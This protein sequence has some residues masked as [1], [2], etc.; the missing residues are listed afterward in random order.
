MKKLKVLLASSEIV[1]FAKT[2]GL[3]DVAGSLPLALEETSVD[4]R[5]I[6]PKYAAVKASGKE[7]R[8]GKAIKVYFVENDG[9]FKRPE[10]YGDKFG[11]YKDNL[12][13][14]AFFSREVL[15]RCK[16]EGFTPDII[17]CNDWQTALVPV[18]LKTIY[19]YDPFFA[20]TKTLFS[21][22][23]LAYQGLFQKEEYPKIGLDW[24]LFSI[25][26]F[27]FYDKVNLMK[28]GL[29]YADAINT[30][31]PTY[32][33]E[34]LA[35]EF[36]CGLEGVLR[37]REDDLYGILNGIDYRLWSPETDSRI[38]KKYSSQTLEDKYVNKESL[39][40][41]AGL[42]VDA[43]IPLFGLISRLADQK[44][45][46][47]LAKI[48][49]R[50]LSL[51]TQFILLG[52][53]E[54]RYHVLFERV[55]EAHARDVSIN[56]KFDAILAQKIYAGCD[57]FLMPSRYEPCG[58][59]Q[60]ISFRYG[61]IPIVRQTGGLKDSVTEYNPKTEKGSGFTFVE[62]TPE[63]LF[64]AVQK[65]LAL[66]RQRERYVRLVKNVMKLD[67]SWERSAKEYVKLYNKILGL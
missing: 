15:E 14:F 57:F 20:A 27:E 8:L 18:Y 54:N 25:N 21:V 22:H 4:I 1:P 17:H 60:I 65:A 16:A 46:D 3:A 10:L 13:R 37:T 61:T 59:S 33:K 49:S 11:D 51:K 62:A 35:P 38:F 63:G 6:M 43:D 45:V 30:V 67:F 44:G 24:S 47:L 66:Y 12:D 34:I 56:L 31:S 28:A 19:K 48:I 26:Y 55:A 64:A 52:T 53:G 41:E 7:A 42:K 9:Y 32:A 40:K 29:I 39:Q 2:G 23:N 5:L 36:G 58:L 50:M